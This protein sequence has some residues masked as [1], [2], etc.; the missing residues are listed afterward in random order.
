[1]GLL[2]VYAEQNDVESTATFDRALGFG[3]WRP[4]EMI[5]SRLDGLVRSVDVRS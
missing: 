4:V 5:R 3:H 1:M 2:G